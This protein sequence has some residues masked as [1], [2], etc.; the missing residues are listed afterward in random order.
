MLN[1]VRPA[2]IWKLS[3][4]N[5]V[6]LSETMTFGISKKKPANSSLRNSVTAAIVGFIT[7]PI[8]FRL[9]KASTTTKKYRP[10]SDPAKSMWVRFQDDCANGHNCNIIWG[11]ILEWMNQLTHLLDTSNSLHTLRSRMSS[12]KLFQNSLMEVNIPESQHG[13]SSW[14]SPSTPTVHFG[15]QITGVLMRW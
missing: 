11:A 13:W 9:E 14:Y 5:C 1:V 15:G 7:M 6:P 4:V 12:V 8:A 2:Q 3:D 10:L